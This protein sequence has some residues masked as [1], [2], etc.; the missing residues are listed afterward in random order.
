MASVHDLKSAEVQISIFEVSLAGVT[1]L[2]VL[3]YS[4]G[5]LLR[6]NCTV[7]C[8]PSDEMAS[9][10]SNVDLVGVTPACEFVRHIRLQKSWRFTLK[11]KIVPYF[12]SLEH[13]S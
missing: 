8:S 11:R 9:G 10:L 3:P 13:T 4:C 12:G 5:H 6:E 7:F 2:N 1:G